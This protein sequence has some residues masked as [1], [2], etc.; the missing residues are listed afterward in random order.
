MV[1]N[2]AN[3]GVFEHLAKDGYQEVYTKDINKEN[4]DSYFSGLLSIMRDGIEQPDVQCLKV[5]F[6]LADGNFVKFTLVD[7]WFNIFFWTFP[8][9][10]NEPIT[11][12]HLVDTR[13]ITK[14]YIKN[15]FNMLIKEHAIGV[16]FI[17]LNNLIDETICKFK[18]ID[19]FSMYLA[20]T[21]NFRDT[22]D[23]MEKYPEFNQSIHA[24]L[25]G[26]PIEDVKDV[27]MK[28]T[29]TQIKYIK[30]SDHCLR[31]SFIS[32]EAISPKQFKE[33]SA[34]I[35]TKPDGHGGVFPY[36][37]NHSFMNGGV[38]DPESYV[39]DS[40]VGRTAQ[41]LQKM[42]V[43]TSGAFAR[44]LETNNLDTFFNT[45]PNYICDT[46]NF[47]QVFIK[48]ASWLT[49]YDRRYYKFDPDGPEYLLDKDKDFQLIGQTL[50]FR[51][52]ITCASYAKGNGICRKCYGNMYFVNRD[53]NPGKIAAELLSSVYTQM[54]LSAKHLLESSVIEMKWNPEF[55][56]LFN[57]NLNAISI[58]EDTDTTGMF[59][60]LDSNKI[61]SSEDDDDDS[62]TSDM[63]YDEY[64]TSFDILY[65]NG[66]RITFHTAEDDNIYIT[67]DL[68][69]LLKSRKSKEDDGVYTISLDNLKSI[70][71][72]FTV[73]IQ[74]KEL[75][76][77]LERSKHIIDR[78]KDT[79]SYTKDEIVREFITANTDGGIN[80]SAIHLEVI[81]ANQMRDPD[82]ILEKPNWSI[83]NAP[84]KILTLGSSLNNNPSITVT[85]E[86]QKIG[87]T[88]V[89][90]LSTR[91]C[92]PSIYDLYFMEKPQ[93]F[94]VDRD[95]MVSDAFTINEGTEG[96]VLRDAIYYVDDSDDGM[97]R[98][99]D[100]Q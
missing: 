88:L 31:D 46:K 27:G 18:Y 25:T 97:E 56:D 60:I 81:L 68:N 57:V 82:N 52:P 9:Y 84:Y 99:V 100:D 1:T 59:M 4:Y 96:M 93:E 62:G 79:S 63:I 87:R 94:M 2:Y 74:N 92:K 83:R 76:Q 85:L 70:P 43:G 75:Q 72:I 40:S 51:S 77:T 37:I 36:V 38:S 5:G 3:Y 30:S 58:D 6:H 55:Y 23:L 29:Q 35:G 53:I 48:D 22:L 19:E 98:G 49:M 45:D 50:Y 95:S 21:V 12:K 80:V 34:N 24:D 26:V 39:I 67:E 10:L 54:L 14:K 42:N 15:Y 73:K 16:D 89:S 20:N 78:E 66:Q 86:Y 8:I 91:K 13:A 64:T 61:D 28:Y 33:V 11:V 7:S 41:I 69:K 47:I 17:T 71:V 90:P 65:P 32:G 44:L